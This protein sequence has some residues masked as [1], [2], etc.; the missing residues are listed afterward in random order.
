MG[1]FNLTPHEEPIRE[2]TK[3]LD[4]AQAISKSIHQGPP[5]T[6]NGFTNTTEKKI[7]YFFTQNLEVLSHSHINR[8]RPNGKQI[9]D[10]LAVLIQIKNR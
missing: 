1:D 9:S 8:K 10:H 3:Q 6:F 4:D 5:G 7:D 2:L